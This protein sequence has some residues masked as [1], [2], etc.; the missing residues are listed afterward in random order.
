LQQRGLYGKS[1]VF[2]WPG[3]SLC[4]HNLRL[5]PDVIIINADLIGTEENNITL[6]DLLDRIRAM[7]YI[8]EVIFPPRSSIAA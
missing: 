7:R 4:Y 1:K 8:K 2:V 3:L 5:R 6:E